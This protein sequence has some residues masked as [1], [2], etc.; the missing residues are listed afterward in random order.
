MYISA[1][2]NR[3]NRQLIANS[4]RRTIAVQALIFGQ[5]FISP[6]IIAVIFNGNDPSS[7]Q[8]FYSTFILFVTNLFAYYFT[9]RFF[10]SRALLPAKY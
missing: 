6:I 10:I 5:L 2:S 8:M 7:N 4:K 1:P 3:D 9:L